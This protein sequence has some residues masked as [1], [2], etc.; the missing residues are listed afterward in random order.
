MQFRF[1]NNDFCLFL[2]TR[3]KGLK[4]LAK[5]KAFSDFGICEFEKG[6]QFEN[7]GFNR[8]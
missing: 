7:K 5:K 6:F 2:A 1:R 4:K 8:D 3:N